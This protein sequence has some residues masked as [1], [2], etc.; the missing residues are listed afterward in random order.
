MLKR[1]L[2]AN[3]LG[4]GWVAVMSLAFIP[5]F[6]HY[7]GMEAYGLIG[8]Y[9]VLQAWLGLLDLGMTPALSREMAR[10]TAGLHSERSIRDL[11][12]SVELVATAVAVITAGVLWLVS[13]WVATDWLQ[14]EKLPED[15]VAQ[16]IGIMGAVTALRFVEGIYRGALVG[17]QR[18]VLFNVLNGIMSTIR[19]VGA[20]V[21][22]AAV[23]ASIQAF[24]IWQGIVS[25][26]GVALI[27]GATYRSLP[28]V[29]GG[30]RFSLVALKSISRFAG[31][32][33]GITFLSL[34]LMQ[35]DKVLLSKLLTLEAYGHYVLA[36]AVAGGLYTLIGPITQAWYPR[37]T[38]LHAR[39]D[40]VEL[41]TTYHLGA[42][43]V[44]VVM[45]SIAI[46]LA[47]FAKPILLMWTRDVELAQRSA[48]LLSLLAIG[49]LLNGLMVLP[50]QT[51]L[52]H[53]WTSLTI[54]INIVA[55]LLV[56]PAILWAT[57]RYGGEGAAWIWLG[58]NAGYLLIGV[59]FMYHRIL[60]GEKSRW[61]L[62]DVVGP[63]LGA[64]AVTVGAWGLSQAG[65]APWLQFVVIP[66]AG[67]F[68]MLAASM[69]APQVRAHI[70]T[71]LTPAPR[72][73]IR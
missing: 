56:I 49:N 65:Q 41:A 55:V 28:A 45:G 17:L 46:V 36:A 2:I 70:L 9:A 24:F 71:M 61:Y 40:Q 62:Q 47:V 63:L 20:V 51:Q 12:R 54:R 4:H 72:K 30:G 66:L 6:I 64:L 34:L 25:M 67:L 21:V 33:V 59:Q 44:S 73:P 38:E 42:Q 27:A 50:Y 37:L 60:R 69:I 14:S 5:V 7:L 11:L 52:A 13:G 10:F 1:N 3:Y 58:L 15:V 53:G 19:W 31:G 68:A 8:L 32:L 16:A 35:V 39:E 18:Q 26:A 57:P 22:L 29:P 43:I 23:S 48:P